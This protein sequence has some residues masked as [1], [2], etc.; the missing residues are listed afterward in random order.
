MIDAAMPM[1]A[2]TVAITASG[3]LAVVAV[4]RD[5]RPARARWPSFSV[6]CLERQVEPAADDRQT[7]QHDERQ[8]HDRRALV[9]LRSRRAR[10]APRERRASA[11]CRRTP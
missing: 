2:T 9:R 8:Q 3:S 4:V 6:L 1:S 10:R 11:P 7:G 5:R